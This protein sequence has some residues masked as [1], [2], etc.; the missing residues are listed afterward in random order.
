MFAAEYLARVGFAALLGPQPGPD[1]DDWGDDLAPS[2]EAIAL[3]TPEQ[4]DR[5]R[6]VLLSRRPQ[7][8]QHGDGV[9]WIRRITWPDRVPGLKTWA[10]QSDLVKIVRKL[11]DAIPEGG[12]IDL[13]EFRA[14]ILGASG[15]DALSCQDARDIGFSPAAIDMPVQQ[16]VGLELLAIVGA[17]C[18]PLVSYARRECGFVH[19][20]RTWRFAVEQRGTSYHSRWGPIREEVISHAR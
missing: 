5:V 4:H 10:G 19:D 7:P 12:E 18:V 13:F 2:G 3:P 15:I 11:Q 9:R 20:G 6:S 1:A 14:P 17:E 16:R 8:E